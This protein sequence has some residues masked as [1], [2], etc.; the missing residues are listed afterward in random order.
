[1]PLVVLK[2][3]TRLWARSETA[4]PFVPVIPVVVA[5]LGAIVAWPA[6]LRCTLLVRAYRQIP[7]LQPALAAVWL[8]AVLGWLVEDSGVTVPAA[9]LPLALPLVAVILLSLPPGDP[10]EATAGRSASPARAARLSLGG[11][12]T[13]TPGP[14]GGASRLAPDRAGGGIE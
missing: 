8:T 1:M 2:Y 4:N 11:A 6:R 5:V 7:L 14:P 12:S 10:G 13:L 3:K 9:A